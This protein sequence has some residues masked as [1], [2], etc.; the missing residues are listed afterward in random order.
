MVPSEKSW[1]PGPKK[2]GG[3]EPVSM[4][5]TGSGQDMTSLDSDYG[6]GNDDLDPWEFIA[7]R[8]VEMSIEEFRKWTG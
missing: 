3:E 6:R 5:K 8:V 2:G 1:L 7:M 4:G